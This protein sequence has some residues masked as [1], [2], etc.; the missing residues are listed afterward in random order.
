MPDVIFYR[1]GDGSTPMLDWLDH[2]PQEARVQCIGKI[3]LL[4]A[5]GHEL[6]R[7]HA[8]YLRDGIH[9]LRAKSRGVNYRMLYFFHG[10][11][12]VVLSHGV[13]KQQATVPPIEIERARRRKQT[14]EAEPQ[15]HTHKET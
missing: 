15:Q 11:Q 14:F 3:E 9:E 10:R 12:A 7:P 13:T 1:E 4:T 5:R 6:R 8:D 2:L